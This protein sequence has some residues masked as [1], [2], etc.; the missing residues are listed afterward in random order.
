MKKI[1]VLLLVL[2]FALQLQPIVFAQS[3]IKVACIGDSITYGAGEETLYSYPNQLQELLGLGYEVKNYGVGGTCMIKASASPYWNT[4]HF[5]LAKA[6]NPDI[7][8]IM[9]GTN[10]SKADAWKYKDEY[11]SAYADMVNIFQELPSHPQVYVM[12]SPFAYG[13]AFTIEADVIS[14]EI[15]PLQRQF[16]S[17]NGLPIIDIYNATQ[18]MSYNFPDK[19]HPNRNGYAVIAQMVYEALDSSTYPPVTNIALD[20]TNDSVLVGNTTTLTPILTPSDANPRVVWSS[21]DKTVATVLNGVVTGVK[22]GNAVI[23]ATAHGTDLAATCNIAV[24]STPPLNISVSPNSANVSLGKKVQLTANFL[25]KSANKLA[26]WSSE[27]EEI[28][29]VDNNGIVTAVG[30]G[31]ATVTATAVEMSAAGE[32][33]SA[34]ANITVTEKLLDIPKNRISARIP[35]LLPI[36]KDELHISDSSVGTYWV[37]GTGAISGVVVF[38]LGNSDFDNLP[39]QSVS[40][41]GVK[42]ATV[43]SFQPTIFNIWYSNTTDDESE[44]RRIGDKNIAFQYKIE[45]DIEEAYYEFPAAVQA[46]YIKIELPEENKRLAEITFTGDMAIGEDAAIK[47]ISTSVSPITPVTAIYDKNYDTSCRFNVTGNIATI[48]LTEQTKVNAIRFTPYINSSGWVQYPVLGYEMGSEI[49]YSTDGLKYYDA[50]TN[51]ETLT[52]IKKSFRPGTSL[53]LTYYYDV[54]EGKVNGNFANTNNVYIGQTYDFVVYFS[55]PVDA[56]YIR[57]SVPEKSGV[58]QY[59]TEVAVEKTPP[60]GYAPA[61]NVTLDKTAAEI[62]VKDT[63]KL[64]ATV[65]PEDANPNVKWSSSDETVAVVSRGVV[66]GV[67]SGTAVITAAAIDNSA[68]ASCAVTVMADFPE[69][70]QIVSELSDL[71]VGATCRLSA[72]ILPKTA[73]TAV[74]WTSSDETVAVVDQSGLVTAI[75]M[76]NAV[77]TALV[78]DANAAGSS[79]YDTKEIRVIPKPFDIPKNRISVRI[80]NRASDEPYIIDNNYGSFWNTWSN[81][82]S[83]RVAIFNLGNTIFENEPLYS[84]TVKGVKIVSRDLANNAKNMNIWYSKTVNSNDAY[85]SLGNNVGL[86]YISQNGMN[87]AFYDFPEPVQAKYIKVEFPAEYRTTAEITFTGVAFD[88]YEIPAADLSLISADGFTSASNMLDGN[89]T[90]YGRSVTPSAATIA[91]KSPKYVSAIRFTPYMTAGGTPN[92]AIA[93]SQ[94]SYSV[95]GETYYDVMTNDTVLTDITSGFQ[96]AQA[97]NY[98]YSSFNPQTGNNNI[99]G[100]EYTDMAQCKESVIH[101]KTPVFAKYI[102]FTTQITGNTYISEVSL[103]TIAPKEFSIDNVSKD[104]KGAVSGVIYYSPTDMAEKMHF[105]VAIYN[106]KG[107]LKSLSIKKEMP[108]SGGN[109]VEVDGMP[110]TSITDEIKVFA[111]KDINTLAPYCEPYTTLK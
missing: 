15:V 9:L 107:L 33:L 80:P 67:K 55:Y 109:I 18:D 62:M 35:N 30:M 102:R 11:L 66:T 74:I 20:K 88:I 91:L 83:A 27:N 42:F 31:S 69:S 4:T 51:S 16:A 71:Y 59:I 2:T 106:E 96:N 73:N 39:T 108:I 1:F 14:N 47:S 104:D 61:T 78:K 92:F 22:S 41:S 58:N 10:D 52:P 49:S 32:T 38:N 25:P 93:S 65:M 90:T 43:L 45:N 40:V 60:N 68:Y 105:V 89:Y 53:Q 34:T 100:T 79:V 6:Y 101:F 111:F 63:V 13:N 97:P 29:T 24:S 56:K 94:V 57:F 64:S 44:Y 3:T 12:T 17:D 7:V 81:A 98:Y 19:I 76:G 84:V 5:Q 77:I 48:E 75:G 37:T 23:T 46:R 54:A 87:E 72:D 85:I 110:G 8:L 95:D 21:S 82:D 28:I 36:A 50:I 99:F 70:V 86:T 103:E 26:T